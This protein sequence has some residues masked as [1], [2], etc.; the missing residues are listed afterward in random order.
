[1]FDFL[2]FSYGLT[3]CSYS[4]FVVGEVIDLV[5]WDEANSIGRFESALL[6]VTDSAIPIFGDPICEEEP[7]YASCFAPPLHIF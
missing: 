2:S 7:I 3:I 5:D 6:Y 4:L 1:M